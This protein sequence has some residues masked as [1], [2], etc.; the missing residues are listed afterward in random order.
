MKFVTLENHGVKKGVQSHKFY[1]LYENADGTITV[2]YGRC[3]TNGT[4]IEY[5]ISDWD[6]LLSSKIKGG[7]SIIEEAD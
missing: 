4:Q 6:K 2:T 7:Y 5:P 3:G 1:S